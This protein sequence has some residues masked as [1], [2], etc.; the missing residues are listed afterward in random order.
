[1]QVVGV[2]FGT[3]N[4][5]ISVWDSEQYASPETKRLGFGIDRGYPMPAVVALRQDADGEVEIIVGE[6]ADGLGNIPGSVKVIPNI[7]RLALSSDSYVAWHLQSRGTLSEE[8]EWPPEGWNP[9]TLRFEAFGQ[10]F[11]I[12]DLIGELLA[13]AFRLA[14]ISGDYEWRAGC[15][16]HS[17]LSYRSGLAETLGKVTGKKGPLHWVLEEPVLFLLAARKLGELKDGSYLVYDVGGGSFDCALVEVKGTETTIF[18][19]EGHPK[20][21]GS[22]IDDWLERRFQARGHS[23]QRRVLRQAKET[24]SLA[25]PSY[26]LPGDNV[27][28]LEDVR[29][30]LKGLKFLEQSASVSRDAYTDAKLLW[31]RPKGPGYFPMG[32]VVHQYSDTLEVSFVW[33][34]MWEDLASE[35]DAI[36]LFGGPTKSH[37]FR[38]YLE[39]LFGASKVIEAQEL[40]SQDHDLAITGASIGA[41]YSWEPSY[42]P[43]AVGYTPTYA[44]RLPVL[45]TLRDLQTDKT[46]EYKPFQNFT[47]SSVKIFEDFVSEDRLTEQPDDPHSGQRYELTVANLEGVVLDRQP[48]DPQID[49]RLAGFTLRLVIDR[50]GRVGVEQESEKSSAKRLLVLESTPWQTD[51]QRESLK[52]IFE[53]DRKYRQE[54][55]VPWGSSWR[56]D[57]KEQQR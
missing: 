46:I 22:D 37:L 18:G 11:P 52:Y 44:N 32:E 41:C 2:D 39:N 30:S 17:D 57:Y 12:W 13:E 26:S 16:V 38:E 20:L 53:E 3:T 27:L 55:H 1:M 4:I 29:A 49:T 51:L 9:E 25:N 23:I 6:P 7:K 19:A 40:D 28:T 47:P 24:I 14:N 54:Y 35:V 50:Q 5:R 8:D 31:N 15:P 43:R 56:E 33:Q 21:G 10:E 48:V 42:N 45:V 36:I 34:L